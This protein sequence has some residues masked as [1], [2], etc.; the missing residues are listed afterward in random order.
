MRY[1]VLLL[2][3]FSTYT[4]AQNNA[5][6]NSDSI[7]ADGLL[8]N[9]NWKWHAGDIA[10]WAKNSFDDSKW[11]AIDPSIVIPELQPGISKQPLWLRLK[12]STKNIKKSLILSIKQSGATEI[13]LNN[14]KIHS[15][16]SIDTLN[17]KIKSYDPNGAYIT[18]PIDSAENVLAIR[19][20]F[21]KEVRY[22]SVFDS[23]F[24]LFSARVFS[25]RTAI[26]SDKNKSAFIW[27]GVNIGVPLILFVVHFILFLFYSP[28][29]AN[30][31]YSLWALCSAI[32]SFILLQI[33]ME[34][35]IAYKNEY[36][37]YASVLLGLGNLA[38]VYSLF[39]LL[40]LKSK[41][42]FIVFLILTLFSFI[43]FLSESQLS[44]TLSFGVSILFNL[45]VLYIAYS[46]YKQGNIGGKYVMYSMVLYIII[47][48]LFIFSFDIFNIGWIADVLFH[49]ALFCL[50][51]MISILLGIDTRNTHTNLINVTLE[52]QQL[53]ENQN[54]VLERQ[55]T[56]RTAAL[57]KSLND[58]HSTQAQLIHSEKMASLGELTAGI[59]HEIQNPLN[60]VNNFSELNNELIQDAQAELKKM[61]HP[62]P[63]ISIEPI[64]EIL[65]DIKI[66]S[67]KIH[68]HGHRASSIVKN[69]LEHSRVSTGE[70]SEVDLNVLCEEYIR[71]SYQ[72]MR[73]K[74]PQ[75]AQRT[76]G[77][78]HKDFFADYKTNLDPDL[79]KI[80]VVAQDIARVLLNLCNNAFY[81]VDLQR[82]KSDESFKPLVTLATQ[83]LDN[84][85]QIMITDNGP[86]IPDSL[87]DKIFQPFF[88]TKPTGQGTGLGLSLAYDII[89]AHGGE[90]KVES[91]QNEGTSFIITLPIQI[92]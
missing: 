83:C 87:K 40:R 9:K 45:S 11:E 32:G 56:E 77:A 5:F 58:L 29:R 42:L 46:A 68:I 53:L 47:W 22:K 31:W 44:F 39:L 88:T 25:D 12:F 37:L 7:P 3:F 52:K 66:N 34:H 89:K 30:L 18:L 28:V 91:M 61:I 90:I 57:N 50:P 63:A 10:D 71:L 73:S 72:G 49:I 74:N 38:L 24:P 8:L 4:L 80:R 62:E 86:G 65:D 70:K 35:Q 15:F 92:N 67:E 55:V 79:P 60:F 51:I 1:F 6:F 14:Y 26:E 19:Y 48:T 76:P 13:F 43:I 41:K 36:T 2:L 16:G 17:S 78:A 59:A 20:H 54:Q 64:Q 81:A 33:K 84:K 82:K 69:M 23:R 21:E 75:D 27:E 85:I